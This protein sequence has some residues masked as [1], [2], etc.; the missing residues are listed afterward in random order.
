MKLL[1]SIYW[2]GI[3]LTEHF[4]FLI[5]NFVLNLKSRTE[6]NFLVLSNQK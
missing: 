3:K 6:I 4:L 1:I 2:L 5:S